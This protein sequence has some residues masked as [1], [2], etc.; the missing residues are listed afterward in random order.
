MDGQ[1]NVQLYTPCADGKE[2]MPMVAKAMR[3]IHIDHL[4]PI[5]SIL[6]SMARE[7]K[8]P[9]LDAVTKIFRREKVKGVESNFTQRKAGTAVRSYLLR[10]ERC[11]EELVEMFVP[12][13]EELQEVAKSSQLQLMQASENSKKGRKC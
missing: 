5:S 6:V 10:D 9:T 8:L 1:E 7:D 12:M 2:K 3:Y 11:R 4:T 13:F